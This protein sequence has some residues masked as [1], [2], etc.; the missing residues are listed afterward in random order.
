MLVAVR[1]AQVLGAAAVRLVDPAPG[2]VGVYRARY[3]FG[4]AGAER[5]GTYCEMSI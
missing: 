4:P 5:G 3:G 2:L 1:Y